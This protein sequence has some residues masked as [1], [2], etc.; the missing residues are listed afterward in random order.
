L[1]LRTL[2]IEDVQ[3]ADIVVVASNLF[4]SSVYLANLEALSGAGTLPTQGGRYF[5]AK[6]DEIINGLR[7]QTETLM[8]EGPEQV[9]REIQDKMNGALF[10]SAETY[11]CVSFYYRMLVIPQQTQV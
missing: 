9:M 7:K 11:A 8:T 5:N 4:H 6:L 1:N 3:E 2:T 10:Y